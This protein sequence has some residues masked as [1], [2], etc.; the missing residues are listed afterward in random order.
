[1]GNLISIP[2]PVAQ[3]AWTNIKIY[4]C[5]TQGGS[6]TLLTT[7]TLVVATPVTLYYD[8]PGLKTDWYYYTYYD[9]VG[10]VTSAASDKFQAQAFTTTY[11]QPHDVA[12]HLQ[13]KNSQGIHQYDGQTNPSIFEIIGHIQSAEDEIDRATNHAWRLRYSGTETGNATAANYEY[14]D[15]PDVIDLVEGGKVYLNHRKI[16]TLS[17][18]ALDALEVWNGS[19]YVD[20]L[21]TKTEGRGQDYWV[22]YDKGVLIMYD[23]LMSIE[24]AIRIKYRYGDTSVPSDINHACAMM[25]CQEAILSDDRSVMLPAGGDNVSLQS[26]IERYQKEVEKILSSRGESRFLKRT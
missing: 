6:Y 23:P 4:H 20:Y 22:D 26:K 1:M 5:A 12:Q 8:E 2:A 21:A 7:L 25:V 10:P 15:A 11:C 17:A 16:Y 14:Y 3:S 9:S 19:A 24:K 13:V 18:A